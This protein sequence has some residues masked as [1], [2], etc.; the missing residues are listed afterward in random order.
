[1]IIYQVF[2]TVPSDIESDWRTWMLEEHIKDVLDTEMF[3]GYKLSKVI[4][5]EV[6]NATRFCIQ[7]F[8]RT[9]EDYEQYRRDFAPVL[10]AAHNAKYGTQIAVDRTVMS[11][12]K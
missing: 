1:M 7:Y 12:I 6:E 10:Q 2:C 8:A 3:T 4:K 9:E 5:P 11:V